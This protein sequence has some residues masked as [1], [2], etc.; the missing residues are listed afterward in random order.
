MSN[1]TAKEILNT[2]KGP[3]TKWIQ[4]FSNYTI[5]KELRYRI[6]KDLKKLNNNKT[7]KAAKKWARDM[8]RY[9]SKDELQMANRQIKTCSGSLVIRE[10]QIETK[11]S[12]HLVRMASI[13]EIKK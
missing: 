3:Q 12:G 13:Q 7:N 11:V 2:V 8:D 5:D 1:S 9:F 10:M 4:V 6:H